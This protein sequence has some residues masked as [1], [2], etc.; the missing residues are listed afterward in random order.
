M[1]LY[2]SKLFYESLHAS[3]FCQRVIYPK[4]AL[5]LDGAS[6][7]DRMHPRQ[8]GWREAETS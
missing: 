2:F 7:T 3:H 4:K 5:R 1:I 6:D 8:I